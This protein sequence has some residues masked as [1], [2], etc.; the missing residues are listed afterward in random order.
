MNELA[1]KKR[2]NTRTFYNVIMI[3]ALVIEVI[4]VALGMFL[5]DKNIAMIF[6]II[7][8]I[9]FVVFIT[10]NIIFTVMMRK[11]ENKEFS[12]IN[13]MMNQGKYQETIEYLLNWEAKNYYDI[14]NYREAIIL[15]MI[16]YCDLMLNNVDEAYNYLEQIEIEKQLKNESGNDCYVIYDAMALFFLSSINKYKHN[17]KLT[18]YY[19][20]LYLN[21]KDRLMNC[22]KKEESLVKKL[23]DLELLFTL[24]IE[25]KEIDI[26]KV[27]DNACFKM[28]YIRE[29]LKLN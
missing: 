24:I 12:I 5:K 8:I 20:D 13:N 11:N 16:A 23:N 17:D 10:L 2:K 28:Q 1:K 3:S 25:E 6:N 21:E 9:V 29:L 26:A 22:V 14:N 7:G 27:A 15:Y 4:S 19:Y 18:K